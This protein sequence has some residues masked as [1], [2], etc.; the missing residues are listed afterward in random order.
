M[1]PSVLASY[2]GLGTVR[3]RRSTFFNS[4]LGKDQAEAVRHEIIRAL[5]DYSAQTKAEDAIGDFLKTVGKDRTAPTL[6]RAALSGLSK[7]NLNA[8]LKRLE[9]V[10]PLIKHKD[11]ETAQLAI[12]V[13]AKA[14]ATSSSQPLIDHLDYNQRVLKGSFD[15]IGDRC[16]GQ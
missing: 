4:L 15:Y 11:V 14:P 6:I 5:S 12:R 3:D 8:R 13:L 2:P 16:D 9:A 1:E 10:V 7:F